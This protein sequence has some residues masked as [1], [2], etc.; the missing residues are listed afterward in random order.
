MLLLKI[1][2]GII[3]YIG[4]CLVVGHIK[5]AEKVK[6]HILGF[7]SVIY[8][9]FLGYGNT[10][11]VLILY[12][13]FSNQPKGSAYYIPENEAGMNAMFGVITLIIYLLILIPIN[14]FFKKKSKITTKIYTI[15]S[16]IATVI[17][18]LVYWIFLDKSKKLF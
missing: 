5:F 6:R 9:A 14:I 4:I 2:L 15:M 8:N 10:I 16:T 18:T 17:G 13:Y 3:I 11:L 12:G 1:L 7:L